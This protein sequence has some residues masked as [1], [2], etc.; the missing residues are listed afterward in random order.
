MWGSGFRVGVCDL[1]PAFGMLPIGSHLLYALN[2]IF[3]PP[4]RATLNPIHH[5]EYCKSCPHFL[6]DQDNQAKR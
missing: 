2:P 4:P 5:M 3:T 6:I 1:K